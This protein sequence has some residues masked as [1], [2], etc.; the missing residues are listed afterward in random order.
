MLA[1][2]RSPAP[3]PTPQMSSS[4]RGPSSVSL[5]R[6]GSSYCASF[7]QTNR[8]AD[9]SNFGTL[10]H[11]LLGASVIGG[12]LSLFATNVV[13]SSESW[14]E[15]LEAEAKLKEEEKR[16]EEEEAREGQ[17]VLRQSRLEFEM[18][19]IRSALTPTLVRSLG[20]LVLWLLVGT[21]YGMLVEGW[22][23]VG[24]LYFAVTACSTAGLQGPTPS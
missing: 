22:S 11:V 14:Y 16:V 4:S 19:R 2:A 21:A 13:E 3:S 10:L 24:G 18:E 5:A 20:A 8:W 23:F 1:L 7:S 17:D 9:L 6:G 12:V 15:E